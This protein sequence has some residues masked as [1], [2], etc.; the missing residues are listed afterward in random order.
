MKDFL[1]CGEKNLIELIAY[2]ECVLEKDKRN[3]DIIRDLGELYKNVNTEKSTMYYEMMLDF[4]INC[5]TRCDILEQLGSMYKK[6]NIEKSIMYY[7]KAIDS[8][9]CDAHIELGEIYK[10]M[11]DYEKAIIHIGKAIKLDVNGSHNMLI[12]L[13]NDINELPIEDR[14]KYYRLVVSNKY[15]NVYA[16]QIDI[17]S[18]IFMKNELDEMVSKMHEISFNESG[19]MY[20]DVNKTNKGVKR[21][22]T[23]VCENN[24]GEESDRPIKKMEK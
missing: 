14:Y 18:F 17:T 8:Y 21:I 23:D 9:S 3:I 11:K 22:M 1:C 6:I 19:M 16:E 4:K 13:I 5:D 12:N 7:K 10:N 20:E 24:E 2:Y 15:T